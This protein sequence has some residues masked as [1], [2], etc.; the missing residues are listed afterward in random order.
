M[1][2][3][4]KKKISISIPVFNEQDNIPLLYKK[5]SLLADDLKNDFDFEFLF[6]D[7]RSID[8]TWELISKIAK[9]DKRVKGLKFSKNVGFQKSILMNYTHTTGDAVVQLDA[10]LQDPP[11]MIKTFIKFWMQ[12]NQ[13]V[14]GIRRNRPDSVM[15]KAFRFLGYWVIN[16]LSE[17]KI[18]INAGDFRLLDR[19]VVE[20]LVKLKTASPYLRGMIAELGFDQF[21]IEYDRNPRKAGKT[22]FNVYTLFQMGFGAIFNHSTIPLRISSL[23]GLIIILFSILGAFYYV[24]LKFY[25]PFLPVGIASIHILVLFGVGVNAFLLGIIGEYLQRIF[26]ILRNEPIALIDKTININIKK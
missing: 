16:K 20:A 18:P 10:D 6:T 4:N 17:N 11:E 9:K 5:I 21:G 8:N 13:V 14:F 15:I 2:N 1:I 12:G 22:K 7:N 24:Y 3:K 25:S 26:I 23:L 19:Q